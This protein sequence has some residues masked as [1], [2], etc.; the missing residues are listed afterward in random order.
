MDLALLGLGQIGGS[1]ARAA[2]ASGAADRVVAWTPSG[3]GPSAAGAHGIRS[4]RSAA[5][6]VASG[7]LVVLAAPPLA[8]LALLEELAGPL[9]DAL[10]PDAVITDVAST[11]ATIVGRA[12]ALGLRFVGG[13]PMAGREASGY[14]A[15]DPE[16]ARDR[17]WVIV[18][19]DPA[20]AAA[21]ERVEALARGCGA[22]PIRMSGADHDAATALISHAPLVLS[23][24]LVEAA[25]GRPEWPAAESIAAGGWSGMTRLARGDAAMGAG[26]LATNAAPTAAALRAI[27]DVIEDWIDVLDGSPTGETLAHRLARARD[28]AGTPP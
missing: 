23:A 1:I 8:C 11:K 20:D 21:I 6:T 19:A 3:R 2:L 22:R 13:H 18:P 15:A 16:L 14:E 9:R 12:R 25:V 26:I 27:R 5:E 24:A 4:T 17:P 7:D 28:D 10:R